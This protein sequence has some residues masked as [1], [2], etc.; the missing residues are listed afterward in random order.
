MG[1]SFRKLLYN[2]ILCSIPLRDKEKSN[3]WC[4][5]PLAFS[6]LNHFQLAPSIVGCAVRLTGNVE[7]E[8][9][10]HCVDIAKRNALY[11]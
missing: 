5:E 1:L 9:L 6:F 11:R 2:I 4:R 7:P 3:A 10:E 8:Q